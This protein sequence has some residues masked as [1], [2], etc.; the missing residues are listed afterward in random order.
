MI[1][2][3]LRGKDG[4]LI[5]LGRTYYTRHK[6]AP[7]GSERLL[8]VELSRIDPNSAARTRRSRPPTTPPDG[9]A[10]RRPGPARRRPPTPAGRAAG[11]AAAHGR[12][13]P[14]PGR[15][16]RRD[17]LDHGGRLHQHRGRGRRG[18]HRIRPVR[19][20]H[21]HPGRPRRLDRH[22]RPTPRTHHPRH[23]TSHLAPLRPGRLRGAAPAR[24]QRCA[25]P[26]SPSSS[27]AAATPATDDWSP[28]PTDTRRTNRPNTVRRTQ[29]R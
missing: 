9:R 17:W 22:R 23:P 14:H 7:G 28:S 18:R 20:S 12:L 4:L 10:R 16:R 1:A 19:R 24:T 29:P 27:P 11:P 6:A 5:R 25:P 2:F 3:S 8:P 26:A 15:P 21:P 13:H